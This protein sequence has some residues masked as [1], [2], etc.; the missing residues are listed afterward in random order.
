MAR[1]SGGRNKTQKINFS[2]YINHLELLNQL[3][4]VCGEKKNPNKL[5]SL[6]F[7]AILS[8]TS[9]KSVGV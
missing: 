5:V 4:Q 8:L 2:R 9:I 7:R 3:K 1:K 6:K